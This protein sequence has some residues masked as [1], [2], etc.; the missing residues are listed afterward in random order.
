MITSIGE[1]KDE[2][3]PYQTVKDAMMKRVGNIQDDNNKKR[4]K[5]NNENTSGA[6]ER[7]EEYGKEYDSSDEEIVVPIM[8][9]QQYNYKESCLC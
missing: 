2:S 9:E 4:D 7:D 1:R 8:I 6:L 3:S 5:N